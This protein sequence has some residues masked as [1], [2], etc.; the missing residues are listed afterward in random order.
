MKRSKL[1]KQRYLCLLFIGLILA[2]GMS[3]IPASSAA[4]N[5]SVN[6][7]GNDANTGTAANP[8]QTISTGINNVDNKGTVYLSSGTFNLST[9]SS[10]TDYG[11]TVSKNVTIR[12]AGTN[13]TII[14]AKGLNNVFTIQNSNV[15]IR[16][17]TI[18]NGNSLNG[19]AITNLYG[20]S[21]T[22]INCTFI[23]N[24]A[25]NTGGAIYNAGYLNVTSSTLAMNTAK[26]GY[27]DAIYN[28]N[29]TADIHF[30]T[31]LGTEDNAIYSDGG[32]VNAQNNWWGTNNN[33]GTELENFEDTSNWTPI[34]GATTSVDNI[35]GDIGVL[36]T[37][38]N[39][40]YP[41][42]IKNVNYNFHGVTP[43]LQLWFYV[44]GVASY[45]TNPS[46]LTSIGL[47]LLSSNSSK[48]FQTYMINS[49][50]HQ[51]LNY[52][53]LPQSL[54]V[55]NGGMTW[56]DTISRIEIR[57]FNSA[58]TSTN[59]TFLELK[60]NMDGI[61][62]MVLTFDDGYTSVFT[63]AFPI[64]QKYGIVGTVY[65][66]MGYVGDDGYLTLDQLHQLYDA[67]WTIADHTPVHTD[68]SS[69]PT[70]AD[71][72][73][74][75]QQGTDWLLA[76][77]FTRGAYDFALPFGY[78]NNNVLEALKEC[79]IQTDRIVM[80]RTEANP[81]DDLY[82]ITC[83]G[84]DGAGYP[85][86]TSYTTTA[87]AEDYVNQTI[88]AK[89]TTFYLMHQIVD[90]PTTALQWATADF[91][92]F[93]A[94]IAQMGVRAETVDQ[95]YNQVVGLTF[96]PINYSPWIVMNGTTSANTIPTLGTST[97]IADFT[98]NSNGVNISSQGS[99]PDGTVVKFASDS[100]GTV[101]P[102]I[103][104]TVNGVA[105]TTYKAGSY[106]GISTVNI[107]ANNQTVNVSQN[108]NTQLSVVSA[109]PV[110]GAV[111]VPG[112]KVVTITFNN[113]IEAGSAYNSIVMMNTNANS[114]KPITTS[115][116]GN[117]LTITPTYN[118]L[119]GATYTLT[120]PI[121]CIAD[122]AGNGL[123]TGYTTSFTSNTDT[124]APTVTSIDP[125]NNTSNV[126]S[127]KVINVIFSEPI[128]SGS[129][130]SNIKVV[131]TSNSQQQTITTSISGNTLTITPTTSWAAGTTYKITIPANSITDLSGNS[132]AADYTSNFTG[133]TG[134]DT[135]APTITSTD[136][137]N[138]T[139]ASPTKIMTIIFS[140]PIQAG[141]AF[142]NIIMMNTNENSQKP[143][144]TSI[145]G[146]TLTIT[147]T[148]NWLTGVTYALTIPVN[149]VMDLAGNGLTTAYTTSFTCISDVTAPTVTSIDPANNTNVTSNK[150]INVIFSEPIQSGST[151]SNIKVVNTS[152]SQQQTI[153]TSIS[154]NILTI[155]PTTSWAAGT[156]YKITIPAN[157]ITDLSGNSL[158]ADYTSNFT[159]NT[160]TDTTAPTI[161]GTN[162]VNNAINVLGT[163]IMTI[164]FSEPIQAG[165]TYGN[166]IMMNTNENSQKPITTSI[167]G[168]TLTITPTYNWLSEVTYLL[169]IPAN[170]IVDLAGNNI[171]TDSTVS[172]TV[173]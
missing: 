54:F 9:D 3:S 133:N 83:F 67:G 86:G 114:Q 51:G 53:I 136:P 128:Q 74:I 79:G 156:T 71:V 70:V 98:H 147:P 10:H 121:N 140:E 16:D 163:Q 154:G 20:S 171:A 151:Y 25:T 32:T 61:P 23:N 172:F 14:D 43:S 52:F 73:A 173:A 162:P 135:T 64:M 18:E 57:L 129:T 164:T 99:I 149:C 30:N 29:S 170:S 91:T 93:V 165:T 90:S 33:P 36:L 60:Q 88:E 110:N 12:G 145:S 63:T 24:T 138:N 153:T 42:I 46:N 102:I 78:Y 144:I 106:I 101:N 66:N 108:I 37:G 59:V 152:N 97:I 65:M 126:A 89:S 50:I 40:S 69:L 112:N 139:Y 56:N 82:Q 76:N 7:T 155:T 8:Y 160:G 115:I 45:P 123:T 157:S 84:S 118:W 142:G 26:N 72:V 80:I 2:I 105:S 119:T 94:Y 5:V 146:N 167:S 11:I 120:I 27:G 159:G 44:Y 143:I 169:T 96:A 137:A 58:G 87:M 158:A 131:N 130:Y 31:L 4:T 75:I 21:L 122:L 77:G 19:G 85:N 103:A 95:Y 148:Y 125:A 81:P 41:A 13:K 109:D 104:T 132:L 134:T 168:N 150:V 47:V 141:S 117:T 15:I 17:L 55:S 161:T 107:T 68:L 124:T 92:N 100:L 116:S 1:V 113:P 6:T 62:T 111:N 35:N 127:N 49:E 166:I 39:G 28:H 22:V 48:Y 34:F 38:A